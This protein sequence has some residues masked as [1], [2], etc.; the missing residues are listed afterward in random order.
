MN[1]N[2]GLVDP[3]PDKVRDKKKKRELLAERAQRDFLLWMD[4]VG[5]PLAGEWKGEKLAE[6][7]PPRGQGEVMEMSS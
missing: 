5:L 7:A 4:D 2:W 6:S 1:S 3:L